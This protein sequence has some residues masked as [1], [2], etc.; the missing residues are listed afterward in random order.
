MDLVHLIDPV[1]A[2]IVIGGTLLATALRAG[3]VD[4]RSTVKELAGLWR[5]PFDPDGVRR[6]LAPLANDIR[7]DGVFRARARP[8]GDPALDE[9]IKAMIEGHSASMLMM[10]H[11]VD[12]KKRLARAQRAAVTLAQAADLAPV[13]GLAGTL[14]SLAQL[15]ARG[16]ARGG[17]TA[18][19]TPLESPSAQWASSARAASAGTAATCSSGTPLSAQ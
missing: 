3:Q 2:A 4:C 16:I 17:G 14:V 5:R 11:A 8:T 12:R 9:A 7:R 19:S 1:P 13:F 15:S 6:D 10:H 18:R